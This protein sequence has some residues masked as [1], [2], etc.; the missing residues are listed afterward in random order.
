M[1]LSKTTSWFL[2]FFGNWTHGGGF[3]STMLYCL[4]KG[5]RKA[6]FNWH[7]CLNILTFNTFC[8]SFCPLTDD[9][10]GN[11]PL[12][13]LLALLQAEGAKIEEE[14]EV[15]SL[16]QS[17]STFWSCTR[18]LLGI[19]Q[20]YWILFNFTSDVKIEKS[21]HTWAPKIQKFNRMLSHSWHFEHTGSSSDIIRLFVCKEN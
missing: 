13:T 21:W 5:Y 17:L 1:L 16:P 14:T 20:S 19:V 18:N 3:A 8:F 7:N 9:R 4:Q 10:S 11:T 6:V 12:D 15:T 2:A